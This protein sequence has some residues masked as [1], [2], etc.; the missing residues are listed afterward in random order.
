MRL[1]HILPPAVLGSLLFL[2]SCASSPAAP[3]HI[4]MGIQTS[5]AMALVMVAQDK[6]FFR[7][8]GAD[9]ELKQF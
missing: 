9:V 5:P 6:G 3:A 8:A 4:T 1:A 7:D 2:A